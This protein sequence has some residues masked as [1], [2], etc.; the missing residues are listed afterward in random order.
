[1]NKQ[2]LLSINLTRWLYA[3][4]MPGIFIILVCGLFQVG[5]PAGFSAIIGM[6]LLTA[7]L[8]PAACA[9][10]GWWTGNDILRYLL[11]HQKHL[12]ITSG[13][14]F[15]AHGMASGLF[16]FD[17]TQPWWPQ[18][19]VEALHPVWLLMPVMVLMLI[20]SINAV[21]RRL[22]SSWKDIHALVWLLLIPMMLHGNLAIAFFEKEDFAPATF[23]VVTRVGVALYEAVRLRS[24]RRIR[25]VVLSIVLISIYY[26]M[27]G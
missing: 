23:F 19:T 13:L 5:E 20:T 3:L 24:F 21:Q 15:V 6:V 2:H 26:A 8:L 14:W 22:G 9:R 10:L 27:M 18:F 1:M 4:S 7:T 25:W 12:G 11:R 16:F 17:R